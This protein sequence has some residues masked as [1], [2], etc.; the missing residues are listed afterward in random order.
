MRKLI[1]LFLIVFVALNNNYAQISNGGLPLS[2]KLN[3]KTSV[4]KVEIKSLK[5]SFVNSEDLKFPKDGK[6]PRI[7]YSLST[8]LSLDNSGTWT[9]LPDGSKLWQLQIKSPG[10]LA[11]GVYFDAFHLPIGSNLYLYNE[12]KTQ[13]IG[14]FNWLNND[15]SRL[16]ATEMIYGDIIN[17]EYFEPKE[18]FSKAEFHINNLAYFYRG[19]SDHKNKSWTEPSETCEININCS[20]VGDSWQDEKHGIARLSIL[21]G[22]N[23]Y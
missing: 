22:V 21:I 5:P 19:V 17:L 8:D 1:L 2:F 18:I 7:G 13:I 11:L 14:S 4:D 3:L 6:P 20:P 15:E 10:A 16:F 12:D 9:I 23:S